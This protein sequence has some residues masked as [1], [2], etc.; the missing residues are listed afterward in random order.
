MTEN[1]KLSTLPVR[2]LAK[3]NTPQKDVMLES[4]QQT[5]HFY[6]RVNQYDGLDL[7]KMTHSTL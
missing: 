4:M 1:L 6:G 3:P 2:H 5:G 7:K